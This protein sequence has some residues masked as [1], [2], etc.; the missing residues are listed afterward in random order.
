MVLS[1]GFALDGKG[2]KMSKSIGNVLDPLKVIDKSGA[3]ILRL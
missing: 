2:N 1:H 3:D